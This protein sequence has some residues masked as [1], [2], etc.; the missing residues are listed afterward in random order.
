MKQI[1]SVKIDMRDSAFR[2]VGTLQ[3]A[4]AIL[5]SASI[6]DQAAKDALET[7]KYSIIK[8]ISR[9]WEYAENRALVEG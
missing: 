4:L 3:A 2:E 9:Q 5:Q 7:A 8:A 6:T 1:D